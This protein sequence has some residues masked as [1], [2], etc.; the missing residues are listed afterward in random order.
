MW[1]SGLNLG[2]SLHPLDK[3]VIC[4][5]RNQ[6]PGA[7]GPNKIQFKKCMTT[8]M[9]LLEFLLQK[10]LQFFKGRK[11]NIHGFRSRTLQGVVD[12]GVVG[13]H[14]NCSTK[15]P[16]CFSVSNRFFFVK[17]VNTRHGNGKRKASKEK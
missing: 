12:L 10:R 4:G 15:N 6:D 2:G 16:T 9:L 14:I 8:F 11:K 13:L 17:D 3:R 1:N 5:S 7:V